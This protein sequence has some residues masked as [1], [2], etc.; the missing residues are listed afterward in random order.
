M[1]ASPG[2]ASLFDATA[3]FTVGHLDVTNLVRCPANSVAPGIEEGS[4]HVVPGSAFCAWTL[5]ARGAPGDLGRAHEVLDAV[6]D[7]QYDEPGTPWHGTFAMFA[8]WPRHLEPGAAMFVDYDPNW[9]QF[10]GTALAMCLIDFAQHL[11]APMLE[12]IARGIDLAV[13]GEPADRIVDAYANPALMAAWLEAWWGRRCGDGAL[14]AAG[15]ARAQRVVAGFDAHGAFEEFNSPVYS[16]VD[17]YA[18]RLWQLDAPTERFGAEGA[19][20]E[21]LLWRQ[22]LDYYHPGLLNWVGPYTRSYGPDATRSLTLLGLWL[23]CALGE[24]AAPVPP[25]AHGLAHGHDLMVGP[26]V[27]RLFDPSGI[28]TTPRAVPRQLVQDLP[29]DRQVTAWIGERC[30]LGAE[31]SAHHWSAWPQFM[32]ATIH[33]ATGAGVAVLYLIEPGQLEAVAGPREL[34][35]TAGEPTRWK[36]LSSGPVDVVGRAIIIENW[37][38]DVEGV[39]LTRLG[40]DVVELAAG[41]A[42][43][44]VAER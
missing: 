34:R 31:Q 23:W 42:L 3:A 20:L 25:I 4:L 28:D 11:E 27:A 17:L 43:L 44:K 16:G 12:R 6:L 10:V 38:I 26:V 18:L 5:L 41:A 1:F 7:L 21:A 29:L 33:L 19:R 14:I 9:R 37:Q 2:A 15:D 24:D 40:D 30:M 22:V 39:Q 36:I 8:E 32:P 35:I 13:R